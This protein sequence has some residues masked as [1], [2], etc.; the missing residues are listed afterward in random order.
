MPDIALRALL[1][2]LPQ[3]SQ[4]PGD[5]DTTTISILLSKLSPR[6]VRLASITQPV[7][8]AKKQA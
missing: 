7:R 8:I 6:E 4:V 5:E 1:Y 3:F 2:Y